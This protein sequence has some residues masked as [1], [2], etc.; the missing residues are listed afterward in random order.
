MV[1]YKHAGG[2]ASCSAKQSPADFAC[3]FYGSSFRKYSIQQSP[4]PPPPHTHTHTHTFI[5]PFIHAHARTHT[6]T[7]ECTHTRMHTYAHAHAR[8]HARTHAHARART[9]AH[10]RTLEEGGEGGSGTSSNG[11]VPYQAGAGAHARIVNPPT[12]SR[13]AGQTD[14]QTD[15][16]PAWPPASPAEPASQPLSRT[17]C[18]TTQTHLCY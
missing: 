3:R 18:H 10:T 11:E 6:Y 5:K 8:T 4:P 9:H 15:S 2:S 14:R 1:G 13:P 17:I 16:P 7:Y 12:P